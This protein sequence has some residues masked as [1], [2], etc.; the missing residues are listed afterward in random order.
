MACEISTE[1]ELS[2][3]DFIKILY[4]F[5]D[6]DSLYVCVKKLREDYSLDEINN[7][8]DEEIFK[9]FIESQKDTTNN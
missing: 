3:A 4:E 6:I 1:K 5:D 8:S 2:L 9:Y 7:M